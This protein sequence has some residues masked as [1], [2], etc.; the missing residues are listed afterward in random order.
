VLSRL[1]GRAS[2]LNR[3]KYAELAAP[4]WVCDPT[5]LREETGLTCPT[6]VRAGVAETLAWYRAEGWL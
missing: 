2:V 4:G 5:R 1:R 3:Q 6:T